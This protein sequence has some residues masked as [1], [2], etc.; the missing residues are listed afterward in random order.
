M[1]RKN[2]RNIIQNRRN[3]INYCYF[4][5]IL[6]ISCKENKDIL[7]AD[8][9][10]EYSIYYK[11]DTII[12]HNED[13]PSPE[14]FVKLNNEYYLIENGKK[15]LFFSTL[16]DTIYYDIHEEFRYKVEIKKINSSKF[17]TSYYYFD[18]VRD[19]KAFLFSFQY[20]INYKILK[21]EKGGTIDY[22]PR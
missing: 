17:K 14:K 8:M 13:S 19:V 18:K 3:L 4:I 9:P 7:K 2:M 22:L 5:S 1:K 15:K 11:K 6:F 21:I 10:K 16:S 12:L 20:D